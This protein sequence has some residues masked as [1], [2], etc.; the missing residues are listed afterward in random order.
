MNNDSM[1]VRILN[2]VHLILT[3]DTTHVV[4][5]MSSRFSRH[6]KH[7][8]TAKSFILERLIISDLGYTIET[9][10]LMHVNR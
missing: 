8:N 7:K 9:V 4:P 1:D 5:K 2:I 10:A 6:L 3:Q